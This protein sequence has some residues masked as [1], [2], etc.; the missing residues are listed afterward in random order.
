MNNTLEQIADILQ[1]MLERD[2]R[3]AEETPTEDEQ[4]EDEKRRKVK[5]GKK[6]A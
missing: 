2:G 4:D 5:E 3:P 1:A 6:K